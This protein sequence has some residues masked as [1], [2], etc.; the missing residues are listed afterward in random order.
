MEHY[1][2]FLLDKLT[3]ISGVTGVRSSFVPRRIK[4]KT[5]LPSTTPG[6]PRIREH[7]KRGQGL[8]CLSYQGIFA[9]QH[10]PAGA[11]APPG[12]GRL[13][14]AFDLADV[15]HLQQP[16]ALLL[17]GSPRS[18]SRS[19]VDTHCPL[20]RDISRLSTARCRTPIDRRPTTPSSTLPSPL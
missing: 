11:L 13:C 10:H 7:Q 1:Q 16:A 5:A 18:R 3:H 19:P 15:L 9:G 20:G 14:H 2:H 8:F 12:G 4:H 17:R 6:R